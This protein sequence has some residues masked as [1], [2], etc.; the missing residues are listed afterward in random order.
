MEFSKSLDTLTEEEII[1][2]NENN[3]FTEQYIK[4]TEEY[5]IALKNSPSTDG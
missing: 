5:Y 4:L 1:I 3:S 2:Q